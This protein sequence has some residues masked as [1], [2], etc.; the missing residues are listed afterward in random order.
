MIRAALPHGNG[1]TRRLIG[2]AAQLARAGAQSALLASR[3]DASRW[4]RADLLWPLF[5]RTDR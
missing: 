2:K 5:S 3:G 1:F 4:R